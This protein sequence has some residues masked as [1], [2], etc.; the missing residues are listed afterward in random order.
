MFPLL[1]ALLPTPF[2]AAIDRLDLPDGARVVMLYFA[3]F[4]VKEAAQEWHAE[5]EKREF[6]F[7][8]R[9]PTVE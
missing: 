2:W 5:K 3:R 8:Q 9:L 7:E 6:G 4:F 1:G